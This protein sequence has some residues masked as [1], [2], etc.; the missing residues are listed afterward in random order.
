MVGRLIEIAQS[1]VVVE[2]LDSQFN[3]VINRRDVVDNL[4]LGDLV[5][6]EGKYLS[7]YSI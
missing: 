2:V 5:Y 1:Y 7:L 4:D 3:V 6:I